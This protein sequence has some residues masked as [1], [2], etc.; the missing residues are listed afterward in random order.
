MGDA[1][2]PDAR[3][4]EFDTNANILSGALLFVDQADYEAR[5]NN[6]YRITIRASDEGNK[7]GSL[8]VTVT[9][10]DVDEAPTISGPATIDVNEGHT[11]TLATYR[12]ADPERAF[13]NWGGIG[14]AFALSGRDADRFAFDKQTG[15]L[16]FVASTRFR[17]RSG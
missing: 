9:V 11:R 17:E 15:R 3:Y 4:F 16:S 7:I 2:R 1:Q 8:R 10:T 6:V 14:S 5:A 13:T 12:K